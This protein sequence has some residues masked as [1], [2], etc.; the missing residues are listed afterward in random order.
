MTTR[1]RLAGLALPFVAAVAWLGPSAGAQQNPFLGRWNLTGTG[2]NAAA[3]YWLE[4]T[5]EGGQLGGTFLNRGGSPNKLAAARVENGELVFQGAPRRAGPG[6]EGRARLQ[7]D[8][9]SGTI[10]NGATTVAFVGA[11][12]PRWPPADANARHTFGTPVDLIDGKSMD[13]WTLVRP[14]YPWT[15]ADGLATN[16]PPGSNLI[17]TQKFLD[18]RIHAEY[19]LD[20]GSH[21]G[22]YWRGRYEMQVLGDMGRPVDQISHMSVYGRIAPLVNA[23]KPDHEWNTMD[24]V[25][26]ANKITVTL[27]GQKVHDNT[28]LDAI[29]GNA[30]DANE[31]EPGPIMVVGNDGKI[32]YRRLTVTPITD[33]RR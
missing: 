21:S 10:T 19:R 1:V 28:T 5:E 20:N 27:N 3:V 11:R 16:T 7:G 2:T 25:I 23:S 8:K 33:A 12:P 17:S 4:I 26:V 18:Y 31:L 9:L 6:P 13:A 32:W 15:I 22:I 29:T 24:G 14:E 30:L